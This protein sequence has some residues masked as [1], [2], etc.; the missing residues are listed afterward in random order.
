MT[1]LENETSDSGENPCVAALRHH[2]FTANSTA[3]NA[4]ATGRNS[5]GHAR[6]SG[7]HVGARYADAAASIQAGWDSRRLLIDARV[8]QWAS[9]SFAERSGSHASG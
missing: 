7:E 1:K 2:A 5:Q 9:H 8:S 6:A 4:G 3:R